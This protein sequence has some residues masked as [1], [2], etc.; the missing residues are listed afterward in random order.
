[1]DSKQ[2]FAHQLVGSFV[3][4][5]SAVLPFANRCV[6]A[7]YSFPLCG[8]RMH[9]CLGATHGQLLMCPFAYVRESSSIAFGRLARNL[10]DQAREHTDAVILSKYGDPCSNTYLGSSLDFADPQ[11]RCKRREI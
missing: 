6:H 8:M 9:A 7:G 2:Y 1:M 11:R 10:K 3:L 5:G 4:L